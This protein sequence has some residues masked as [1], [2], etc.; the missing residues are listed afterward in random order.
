MADVTKTGD[1]DGFAKMLAEAGTKFKQNVAKATIDNCHLVK[2]AITSRIE[3][4]QVKPETG[5]PFKR[6]KE[7]HGFPSGNT[8]IMTSSLLNSITHEIRAWNEGYV[9]V[10][11]NVEGKSKDGGRTVPLIN[12][13]YIHEYGS[14]DGR[15]PKRPFIR[16]VAEQIG[17][18]IVANYKKAIDETFKK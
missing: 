14:S 7:K 13:A 11:R 10:N 4:N 17:P 1:W 6:W 5:K 16:P 8:L 3:S 12:I 15:I 9:G 18:K 2:N